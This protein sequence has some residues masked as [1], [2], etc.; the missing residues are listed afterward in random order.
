M[1]MLLAALLL[2][3][4]FFCRADD[5]TN[6]PSPN[7]TSQQKVETLVCIRHGEKP[8]GGLGQLSC[9]GLNRALALPKVLLGKFGNPEFVFAPNP[10]EKIDNLMRGYYYIRPLMTIE[11]TA[12]RCGLPVNTKF[13]FMDIKGLANEV[14]KPEY[15]KATIFIAWEHFM[16]DLFVVDLVKSH[17]GNPAKVPPWPENDYDSIFVVKITRSKG[18]ETVSFTVDHEGLNGMSDAFPEPAK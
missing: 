15:Q 6:A 13:V 9:R 18:H 7:E 1:K 5:P 10:T 12:I 4:V 3:V 8:P 11:P 14:Q 17:G 16:L 2:G